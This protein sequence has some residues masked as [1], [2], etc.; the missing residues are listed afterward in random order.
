LFVNTVVQK[1]LDTSEGFLIK[2]KSGNFFFRRFPSSCL[3]SYCQLTLSTLISGTFISGTNQL[4]DRLDVENL[5]I[6]FSDGAPN[7]ELNQTL[8]EASLLKENAT[9]ISVGI[10]LTGNAK[11]I[12]EDISSD[13][14]A[15][16]VSN[17]QELANEVAHLV[18]LACPT[19]E[20]PEG[21]TSSSSLLNDKCN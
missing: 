15:F 14:R 18:A 10:G 5:V 12:M 21:K 11:T 16:F 3:F 19:T 20:P 13:N 7:E 17:F 4:G 6:L 9:I 2:L 8:P 1:I